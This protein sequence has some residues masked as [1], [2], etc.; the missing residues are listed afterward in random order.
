ME[1][2]SEMKWLGNYIETEIENV[3]RYGVKQ[4]EDLFLESVGNWWE[5]GMKSAADPILGAVE[6]TSELYWNC[7][8]DSS[9]WNAQW[10]WRH[11]LPWGRFSRRGWTRICCSKLQICTRRIPRRWLRWHR[12]RWRRDAAWTHTL[13]CPREISNTL[14]SQ[15]R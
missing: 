2:H 13:T 11:R 9:N 5:I 6:S 14:T 1:C 7:T 12:H 10:I 8:I 4:A 15:Y 3:A